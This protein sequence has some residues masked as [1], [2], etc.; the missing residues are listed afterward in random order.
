MEATEKELELKGSTIL[1][2]P[3]VPS[4]A[5]PVERSTRLDQ[6]LLPDEKRGR[7]PLTKNQYVIRENPDLV[8][9]ERETRKFLRNLSPAHGHRVA[10]VMVWEWATGISVKDYMDAEGKSPNSDL[11]HINKLLEHYFRSYGAPY[12]TNIAGRKILKCWKIPKN[13]YIRQHRPL[14]MELHLEYM[15]KT[16][17]P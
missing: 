1:D 12:A 2:Y 11:R 16:L 6:L 7:M 9:W 14:T 3:G 10:A 17:Y 8:Q 5:A 15:A 13:W 4:T